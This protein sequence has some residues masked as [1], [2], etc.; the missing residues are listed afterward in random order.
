MSGSWSLKNAKPGQIK[1]LK[2]CA[3]HGAQ[4]YFLVLFGRDVRRF[5]VEDVL[6]ALQNGKKSLKKEDG[7]AWNWEQFLQN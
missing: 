3:D 6:D 1:A 4:A 5:D 7:Q 2:M